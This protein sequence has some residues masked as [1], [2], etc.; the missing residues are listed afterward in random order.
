MKPK[1]PSFHAEHDKALSAQRER[2]ESAPIVRDEALHVG[3]AFPTST[4]GHARRARRGMLDEHDE[5]EAISRHALI[6]VT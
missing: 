2:L 5:D 4:T 1:V 6:R 3:G